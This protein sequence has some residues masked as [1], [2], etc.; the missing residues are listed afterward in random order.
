MQDI[1][2]VPLVIRREI[3]ALIAAPLIKGIYRGIRPERS[4]NVT[5]KVIKS[6]ARRMGEVLKRWPGGQ[7]GALSEGH[8]PFQPGRRSGVGDRRS[9]APQGCR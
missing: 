8:V 5:E 4:L 1:N 2:S 6:L 3:E 9:N 7:P